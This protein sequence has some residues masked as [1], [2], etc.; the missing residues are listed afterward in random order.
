MPR[1]KAPPRVN[2]PYP[3][4][5]G[6]RFRVRIFHRNL[7][8]QDLY[9]HTEREAQAAI[10][11]ARRELSAQPQQTIGLLVEAYF[12]EKV[13]QGSTRPETCREQKARLAMFLHPILDEDASL[14][15]VER[16][17]ALYR[18]CVDRPSKKT[19]KPVSAASHRHYLG[20]AKALFA[21]AVRTGLVRDNPFA[22]IAPIGKVSAG[23]PQLRIDEARRFLGEALR[24]YDSHRSELALAATVALLLGM[25]AGEVLSRTVRD[26]DRDGQILWIEGGKSRN[27]RRFLDV[28]DVLRSR[29]KRLAEGREPQSVLFGSGRT[30]KPHSRQ[31][32]WRVVADLCARAQVPRVCPHSLRGLW[33]TLGVQ[34]G[35]VSH[36]VAASLGH[37]SFDMTERHYAQPEAVSGAKTARM[38]ELLSLGGE[39]AIASPQRTAERLL[40]RL[41][42]EVLDSLVAL[43]RN[44]G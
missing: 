42:P 6:T 30:G 32:F 29:L 40:T 39:G 10:A 12:T 43:H 5:G 9:F 3:D 31:V 2:G 17:E 41:P 28:P 22:P 11:T 27:A 21:W 4:R 38:M 7:V 26:V 14:L 37:G 23:K 1:P 19:G 33:A 35:A 24:L 15:S 13:R 8:R 44:R 36:A 20:L 18:D 34:S 16:A 25:R